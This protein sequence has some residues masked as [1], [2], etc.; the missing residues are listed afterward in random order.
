MSLQVCSKAGGVYA[1]DGMSVT[2]NNVTSVVKNTHSQHVAYYYLRLYCEIVNLHLI[3][4]YILLLPPASLL[5]EAFSGPANIQFTGQTSDTLRFRW[6]A[7]GGPSSGYVVQYVPLSGLG[8]P[9]TSELRQ[10]SPGV[11]WILLTNGDNLD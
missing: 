3:V 7:A 5:S 10:V 11:G 1:S 2:L 4:L 9:M 6:S 8:Q